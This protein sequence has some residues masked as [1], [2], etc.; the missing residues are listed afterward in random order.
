MLRDN[1]SRKN[2]APTVTGTAVQP[3]PKVIYP[4]TRFKGIKI[5]GQAQP[6]PIFTNWSGVFQRVA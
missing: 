2:A 1:V 4:A 5:A 3:H 6:Q